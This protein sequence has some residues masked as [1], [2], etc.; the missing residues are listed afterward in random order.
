VRTEF[1]SSQDTCHA[2]VSFLRSSDRVLENVVWDVVDYCF[3]VTKGSESFEIAVGIPGD[4]QDRM[5]QPLLRKLAETWLIHRL[6]HGYEPY[7]EPL[8]C[9]R[10]M[11]VPFTIVD[12]WYLH[13][14][15]PRCPEQASMRMVGGTVRPVLCRAFN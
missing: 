12:Y 4:W 9:R 7:G 5:S 8:R 1:A 11:Q 15:L 14:R 2:N 6:E 3:S 13:G 10:I